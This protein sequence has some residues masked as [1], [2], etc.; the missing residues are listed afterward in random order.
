[1]Y[2]PPTPTLKRLIDVCKQE[3]ILVWISC[4]RIDK[5]VYS[6]PPSS[7]ETSS[8]HISNNI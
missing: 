1:M 4:G 2:N 8:M 5:L 7:E 3:D 6:P